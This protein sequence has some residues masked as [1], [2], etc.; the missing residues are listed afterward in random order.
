M[1]RHLWGIFFRGRHVSADHRPTVLDKLKKASK[2]T[3]KWIDSAQK[4]KCQ[5]E[6][7]MTNWYCCTRENLTSYY[8]HFHSIV[9]IPIHTHLIPVPIPFYPIPI[10]WLIVFPSR[11]NPWDPG[12]PW[13]WGFP[14]GF[15]WVWVWYGY[16]D[17]DESPWVLWV[18]C[19]D[20]W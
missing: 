1:Q 7:T 6:I 17:C 14:W 15:P 16:G 18:I 10:P 4:I 13:V 2:Q 3:I 20:F 19:G 5:L 11:G 9:L 8:G 12:L